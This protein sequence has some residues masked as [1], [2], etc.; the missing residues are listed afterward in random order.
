MTDLITEWGEEDF[1]VTAAVKEDGAVL[2]APTSISLAASIGPS[3]FE[4]WAVQGPADSENTCAVYASFTVAKVNS[5]GELLQEVALSEDRGEVT[6]GVCVK[7]Q[8][9]RLVPHIALLHSLGVGPCFTREDPNL[10]IYAWSSDTISGQTPLSILVHPSWLM[11]EE[12]RV[13]FNKVATV[14]QALYNEDPGAAQVVLAPGAATEKVRATVAIY[15][16]R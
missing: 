8:E 4:A 12:E 9:G 1:W 14:D 11:T 2:V 15:I 13:T 10:P 16:S 7:M 3:T 5:I 6:F